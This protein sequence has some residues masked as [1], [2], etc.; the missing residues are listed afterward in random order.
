LTMAGA[1][2]TGRI[3]I[4]DKF[5][6]PDNSPELLDLANSAS[7]P[8]IPLTGLPANSV[9]VETASALLGTALLDRSAPATPVAANDLKALLTAYTS[10]GYIGVKDDTVSGPAEA[11][12]VVAGQPHTDKDSAQKD[13][14]VVTM[15][16]QFD[17]AG[18][19]VV[20]GS[21]GGNGN[22]VGAVR[23]DPTL[24]KTISTVDNGNTAQ[25]RLV[26]ALAVAEQLVDNK[27]G[28]YGLNAG[29]SSLLPKPKE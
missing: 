15:V 12:V 19:V 16:S 25:G 14:A 6:N 21:W 29:A 26:T 10:A 2:I 11:M 24:A 27:A 28:H 8:T 23:G 22:V 9:G 7:Q 3:D 4:E 18:A 20:S 5:V 13:E 1:T 17:R